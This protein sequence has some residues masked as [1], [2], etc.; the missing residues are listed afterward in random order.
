MKLYK[1]K[2]VSNISYIKD[3]I[4]QK[5]VYC[6]KCDELNDPCEGQFVELKIGE[7]HNQTTGLTANYVKKTPHSV[8]EIL[9]GS[10]I[11]IAAFSGEYNNHVLWT[12]YADAH[13]GICIEYDFPDVMF[14]NSDFPHLNYINKVSYKG[15]PYI[16]S[17]RISKDG[18]SDGIKALDDADAIP[19]LVNKTE[20]WKYE[21][22]YRYLTKSDKLDATNYIKRIILGLN[23]DDRI[24][25]L[26]NKL[27]DGIPIYRMKLNRDVELEISDLY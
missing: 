4:C 11:R 7:E 20:P 17:E 25:I 1:Y 21:N 19:I 27:S 14:A 24:K 15:I 13:S 2:S 18:F 5:A 16:Q 6:A 12:H 10:E 3:L 22:E 26:I 9:T 23:V 8:K